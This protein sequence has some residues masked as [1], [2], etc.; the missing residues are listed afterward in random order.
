MKVNYAKY[1]CLWILQKNF[2]SAF[3]VL[4]CGNQACNNQV[5]HKVFVTKGV[6]LLCTLRMYFW[7]VK[8]N[9]VLN[10]SKSFTIKIATSWIHNTDPI[11][12]K[13]LLQYPANKVLYRDLTLHAQDTFKLTVW[14][15]D[16]YGLSI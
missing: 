3:E 13:Y 15:T 12:M 8:T 16:K 14:M 5:H 4:G 7:H 1:L 9:L 10:D 2:F 11:V 6:L